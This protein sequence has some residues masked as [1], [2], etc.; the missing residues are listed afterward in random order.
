M[1]DAP[2]FALIVGGS[3]IAPREVVDLAPL[4]AGDAF[5]IS[6][7]DPQV[8]F[9]LPAGLA[10]PHGA[11]LQCRLAPGQTIL[12]SAEIEMSDGKGA[13]L[14]RKVRPEVFLGRSQ[15]IEMPVEASELRLHLG[16]HEGLVVLPTLSLEA[17][18]PFAVARNAFRLVRR[19]TGASLFRRARTAIEI[20]RAEGLRG[21]VARVD[22][23]G[24]GLGRAGGVKG[25][26]HL[27]YGAWRSLYAPSGPA[28]GD[29]DV[30]AREA[31]APPL[32]VL[33]LAGA[34]ADGEAP[35]ALQASLERQGLPADR[36]VRL[37][38]DDGDP[39]AT[40]AALGQ[41]WVCVTDPEGVFDPAFVG[42][43]RRLIAAEEADLAYFDDDTVDERGRHRDPDFKPAWDEHLACQQDYLGPLLVRRDRLDPEALR[44]IDDPRNV[45]L[46]IALAASRQGA[47]IAHL[48]EVLFHRRPGSR[49]LDA[50]ALKERERVVARHME[51]LGVAADVA[52]RPGTGTLQVTCR[53][54]E[55]P[56]ISVVIPTRDNLSTLPTAL[57]TLL[58]ITDYPAFDVVVVDNGSQKPETLR[59][60]AGAA[61]GDARLRVHRHDHPFNF[62]EL[63]N[64]GARETSGDLLLLLNDDIEVLEPGWLKTMASHFARPETGA[65]G[66]K[67]LFPEGT[68]QHAGVALGVGGSV[69]G[70]IYLDL[71]ADT[72]LNHDRAQLTRRVSAVTGACLL[73]RRDIFED[74]GGLDEVDL[75]VAYNDVDY[76]LEVARRGHHVIYE[77]RAVLTHHESHSRGRDNNPVKRERLLSEIAFFS[78]KW[79]ELVFHDPY[80]SGNH[81]LFSPHFRYS[82]PPR[83]RTGPRL[84]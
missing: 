49:A 35:K 79:G 37:D 67:L 48:E 34:A 2:P 60:L 57:E 84:R 38:R 9:P 74:I 77:P 50:G 12:G 5:Q 36:I 82:H 28:S 53:V 1:P 18:P 80:Y 23:L 39:V 45:R 68:I 56:S 62:S 29:G 47:R 30:G 31:A 75:K 43:A 70:H 51:A 73:T 71:P 14:R 46:A 16:A 11:Y 20:L 83:R 63:I 52:D 33:V 4:D 65:V 26:P 61:E 17:V 78:T 15:I 41:D 40:L 8:V 55:W 22:A 76:C 10:M 59:F 72:R 66:P 7:P 81:S 44:G 54:A 6:G 32:A 19:R 58:G 69:A 24:H 42:E 64:V 27:E 3:R 25:D 13:P 21:F